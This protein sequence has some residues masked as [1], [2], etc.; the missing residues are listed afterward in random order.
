[1]NSR[2]LT[3]PKA[4]PKPQTD[5]VPAQQQIFWL[6]DTLWNLYGDCRH[7]IFDNRGLRLQQWI[8]QGQ[9]TLVKSGAGRTIYRVRLPE[10]DLYVKHFRVTTPINFLHQLIRQGRAE[11]EFHLAR[12]LADCGVSTITP[13]ALGERWR[14]GVL[15]ESYLLSEAIPEG[16]TLY[17]LIERCV[18]TGRMELTPRQHVHFAHE[19][20][21]LA[22]TI[23][24]TGI[25]HRDLHEKNVIVQPKGEG[26]YRFFILDLHELQLQYPLS[27]KRARRELARMG[28]YFTLRTSM[29]DRY[30][31]FRRYAELRGF[32]RPQIKMLAREIENQT[33]ESRADFWRRRDSRPQFKNSRIVEYRERGVRALAV[34]ELPEQTVRALMR[35]PTR[36]FLDSVVHWWKIGRGTRVAEVEF[37]VFRRNQTLIYKQYAFKGWPESFAACFRDN[38]ALRAWKYGGSLLLRELPTPRPIAFIQT[39]RYGMPHTSYLLTERVSGGLTINQYLDRQM[40]RQDIDD[41]ERR[42]I[43]RGMIEHSAGLLRSLHDRK[44]THRDLKASNI[45]ASAGV[46]PASPVLWIIDLDGVQT[47]MQVPD[48]NRIQNLTRF[49]VSFHANRWVTMTDRLRF[50][51]LYLGRNFHL[52]DDW[53]RLWRR[54]NLQTEKKIQRNLRHGRSVV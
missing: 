11:K 6:G 30:R 5:S 49:Y 19:L 43:I 29:T 20:A 33:S 8:R 45:L 12:L 52:S 23:H 22:A 47:W 7:R 36:P 44:V 40:E 3:I 51:K 4:I 16:I 53:K 28:R 2:S 15:F 18:R 35:D 24:N 31:F 10:L 1:M 46:D 25:E 21:S 42:R 50:L 14:H 54:I 34:Q 38:Q 13:L 17:E 27:W 39:Y 32:K 41:R 26:N 9:A 37:P 48:K